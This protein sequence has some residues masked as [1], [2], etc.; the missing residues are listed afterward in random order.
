MKYG[1]LYDIQ[2]IIIDDRRVYHKTKQG[3]EQSHRI[4]KDPRG[5]SGF[6]CEIKPYLQISGFQVDVPDLVG[7][8]NERARMNTLT[9][10]MALDFTGCYAKGYNNE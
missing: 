5:I 7:C 10:E 6:S 3:Q 1:I 2:C 9:R 4:L 8:Y